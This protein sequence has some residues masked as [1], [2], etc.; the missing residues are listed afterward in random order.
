MKRRIISLF[1]LM[2]LVTGIIGTSYAASPVTSVSCQY[3]G[4]KTNGGSKYFYVKANGT[5]CKLKF[6]MGKGKLDVMGYNFL[7]INDYGSYEV[8]ITD[9]TNN[10]MVKDQ[11]IYH[12]GSS[13]V[14][15][16]AVK[17]RVYKVQVYC[18][19]PRTIA[20]SYYNHHYFNLPTGG[21]IGLYAEPNWNTFPTITAKNQSNCTLYLTQP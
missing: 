19:R 11:D 6:T 3:T 12:C 13:T 15:F 14:Q 20:T 2:V 9:I 8:K 10:S 4:S 16:S 17:N 5:T 7:L 1:L 18:W 21:S